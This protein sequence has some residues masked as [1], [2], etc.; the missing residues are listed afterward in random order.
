MHVE[1]MKKLFLIT[2]IIFLLNG[3]TQK[4]EIRDQDLKVAKMKAGQIYEAPLDGWFV[5]N[6]GVEKML[7][8]IE[9][10]RWMWMDCESK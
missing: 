1:M 3:C 10:Y 7:K 4:L 6:E 5:S 8:A 9:Y 2:L